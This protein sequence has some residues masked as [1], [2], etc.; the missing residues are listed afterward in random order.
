MARRGCSPYAR[1]DSKEQTEGHWSKSQRPVES[2]IPA[3][4]K[5]VGA[6]DR[7]RAAATWRRQ[8]GRRRAHHWRGS[9]LVIGRCRAARAG[10]TSGLCNHRRWS[11]HACLHHGAVGRVRHH[12]RPLHEGGR[13]LHDGRWA[14]GAGI[15]RRHRP[16]RRYRRG[17]HQRPDRRPAARVH[18]LGNA[19]VANRR[20]DLRRKERRLAMTMSKQA[21][22][23]RFNRRGEK[24]KP[25][26]NRGSSVRRRCSS[27]S[28]LRRE[29]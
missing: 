18:R 14:A 8:C 17:R 29:N 11:K 25:G 2:W 28:I 4:A 21:T 23:L 10:R 6:G 16:K 24:A 20:G 12:H 5:V 3:G 22:R 26:D 1:R 15:N 13:G 7:R 9:G 27:W 19:S